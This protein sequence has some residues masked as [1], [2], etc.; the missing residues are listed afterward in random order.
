M[1]RFFAVTLALGGLNPNE[2]IN[3]KSKK[4]FWV[5]FVFTILIYR[6]FILFKRLFLWP[7]KLGIYSFIYSISGIDMSWFLGLFNIFSFNIPQWVYFQ[8]FT[9]YNNWLS[10]WNNTV[11]V[12]SVSLP[13]NKNINLENIYSEQDIPTETENKILNKKKYNH[14]F[15]CNC[16]NWNWYLILL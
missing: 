11:N 14:C 9:L 3:T 10:W 4:A 1:F 12:K 2:L 15:N 16:F 7:F 8:Y 6:Q 13:S 5:G